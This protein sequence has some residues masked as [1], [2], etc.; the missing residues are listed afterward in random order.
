M[1]RRRAGLLLVLAG[2]ATMLGGRGGLGLLAE[3]AWVVGLGMAAGV[4]WRLLGGRNQLPLRLVVHAALTLTAAATTTT[5]S[6]PAF[7]GFVAYAFWLVYRTPSGEH[8]TTG[9][10]II[11]AGVL[12]TLAA[13]AAVDALRP[14]WDA[15][16]VFMLGMTATFTAIYLLP[17]ERG[18]GRWALWPALA[19]AVITVLANDP[20]G[21]F[22]RWWLPLTM[23]GVGVAV[24]GWSRRRR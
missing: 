9:W 21:A 17:R 3:A 8:A 20:T 6:G 16:A 12:T 14:G 10:A 24:L 23:I 22:A 13:V 11:P 1:N 15:G 2:L 18:G 7:L 19:W 4:A 5:L